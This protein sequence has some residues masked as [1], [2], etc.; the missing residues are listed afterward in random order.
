MSKSLYW[1]MIPKAPAEHN[2]DSLKYTL[3]KKIWDSDGSI[4]EGPEI[5]GEDLIP[6]L[7]GIIVGNGSGEMGR[8]AR[9][10]I[11]AIKQFGHVELLIK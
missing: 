6:Y 1:R 8:S 9:K 2:L 5:V 7:E 10:L 11:D 4:G 3:A